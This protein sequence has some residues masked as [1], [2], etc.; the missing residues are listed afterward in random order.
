MTHLSKENQVAVATKKKR[1]NFISE[2]SKNHMLPDDHMNRSC[3]KP[4]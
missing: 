4:P 2:L 1:K 3:K